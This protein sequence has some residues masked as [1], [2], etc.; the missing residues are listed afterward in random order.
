MEK[1]LLEQREHLGIVTINRPDA[2]N[3]FNYDTLIELEKVVESIRINPDIRTVVFTGAGE[4]AFSVGADL[5]ERKT[6]T[7]Q[8]VRRN[9]N[10]IGD[11]FNAVS[12]LPQ[13]TI[14]AMNGYAFGGGMELALACD[15]RIAVS[16][17]TMGL[18]ET[19]LAIIP[20][21]G[22]TQRL[23]RLIGESKAMEL[24]LT[25]KR[26]KSEEALEIGM[27]TKVAHAESFMEE[28]LAF[29]NTILS[30]GPIALQQAKFAIKNGMNTDLQ[31]GLQI[32]RKAYELTIPTED[33]VEAL[34]AFSE[35]R[36]PQFKGK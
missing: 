19:S 35:K 18:T 1:I 15:F 20:G 36:K 22:G 29:G 25:A 7:E 26:L 33:R 9:V 11:V 30:N 8:Q 27:V 31:T 34:E 24:I 16:G 23:P 4:K 3:A 6:L 32:E 10:K 21:A 5:K 13:P 17:T 2:M 14:A 28:V 12:T